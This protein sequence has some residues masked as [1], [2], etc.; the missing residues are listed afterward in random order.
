MLSVGRRG[1]DRD[2]SLGVT[3]STHNYRGYELV[4][5]HENDRYQVTIFDPKGNRVAS[6]ST[7]LER[8][9]AV[10]ERRDTSISFSR[11]DAPHEACAPLKCIIN[12]RGT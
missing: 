7:H 12:Q 3:T 9:G 11:N 8:Q 2:G 4:L 6:T 10:T 5:H 1:E